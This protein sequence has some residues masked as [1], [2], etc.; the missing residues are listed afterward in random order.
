MAST[1]SMTPATNKIV[2]YPW[3]PN[4]DLFPENTLE[5][6]YHHLHMDNI[7]RELVH[8]RELPKD[9]FLAFVTG[10]PETVLMIFVDM[11]TGKYPGI[12]WITDIA[13]TDTILRGVG[14]FAFFREFWGSKLPKECGVRACENWFNDMGFDLIYGL[15]P[16]PNRVARRYCTSLGYRYIAHLP[17]FT[18]YHGETVDG[19]ICMLTKEE[20]NASVNHKELI[21]G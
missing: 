9:E 6:I 15:T 3:H 13:R 20:W 5:K 14:A 4:R 18:C 8:E 21:N 11:E 12:G 1:P 7:Y 2:A 19:L 10:Y 17:D 16:K